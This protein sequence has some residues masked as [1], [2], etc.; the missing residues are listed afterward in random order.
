MRERV[1]DPSHG[2]VLFTAFTAPQPV[3]TEL[4][5]AIPPLDPY[6]TIKGRC[7]D[8]T[9]VKPHPAPLTVGDD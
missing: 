6:R 7:L 4:F 9:K 8:L 5:T 2:H 3:N 1:K